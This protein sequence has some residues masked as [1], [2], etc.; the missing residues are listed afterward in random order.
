[1]NDP[2]LLAS[3]ILAD[4]PWILWPGQPE[5]PLLR[6]V[7]RFGVLSPVDVEETEDGI[8]L[9]AGYRRLHAIGPHARIPV[10]FLPPTNP[11]QRAIYYVATNTGQAWDAWRLVR[12]ARMAIRPEYSGL[13]AEALPLLDLHEKARPWIQ[14][15]A[16]TALPEAWDERLLFNALG[17]ECG[18]YL[19]R[20]D[21]ADRLRLVPLFQNLCWGRNGSLAL[22]EKLYECSRRNASGLAEV[23]VDLDTHRVLNSD[24]SPK[25]KINYI[26]EMLRRLRHPVLHALR[27]EQETL[28][29][30][31]CRETSWSVSRP[32]QFE[33]NKTTFSVTVCSGQEVQ[34]AAQTLFKAAVILDRDRPHP[35]QDAKVCRPKNL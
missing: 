8:V 18:T 2:F 29:S 30:E 6:S 3:E 12:L 27:T 15:L 34:E 1:M 13:A 5:A 22:I 7:T 25:D 23:L 33:T 24:L 21:E 10:R 35:S 14:A 32:D 17:L 9:L 26:L 20:F 19:T 11:V 28:F 16:W 31:F 4:R